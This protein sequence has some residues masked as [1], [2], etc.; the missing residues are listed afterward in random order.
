MHVLRD[1]S[2]GFVGLAQDFLVASHVVG[3]QTL[4]SLLLVLHLLF[5][6]FLLRMLVDDGV[7]LDHAVI[8]WDA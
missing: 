2:V 5:N 6:D 7:K 8:D 4:D 3:L 1:S